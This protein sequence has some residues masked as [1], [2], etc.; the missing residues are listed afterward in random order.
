MITMCFCGFLMLMFLPK[1]EAE[2]ALSFLLGVLVSEKLKSVK[3][4]SKRNLAVITILGF[5]IGASALAFKQL[6]MVREYEGKFVYAIV[7]MMIKLPFAISLV[8]VLSFLPLLLKSR[9][10]MLAGII[11]YELYLM[12]FPS[13]IYLEG[14]L[15][16]AVLLFFGSFIVAYVFNRLNVISN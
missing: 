4:L 12:H 14:R 16:W 11:S 13:Y 5:V 9:Y 1:I 3:S 15:T 2:Q 6:P 7:Q 10:L 8:T